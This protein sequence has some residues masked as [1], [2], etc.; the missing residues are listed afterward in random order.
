MKIKKHTTMKSPNRLLWT[1]FFLLVCFSSIKS[2]SPNSYNLSSIYDFNVTT[3]YDIHQAA[4]NHVWIGT[5]QGL[6][7]FDGVFFKKYSSTNFQTEYSEI[8]ED[9]EGRIWCQNFTGQIF[10]IKNSELVLFKDIN[11]FSIDG[12]FN[13]NI[14]KFPK[15]YISTDQGCFV[16]DFYNFK[17]ETFF[18][19]KDDSFLRNAAPN[20]QF[21]FFDSKTIY[22]DGSDIIVQNNKTK[23]SLFDYSNIYNFSYHLFQEEEER[24]FIVSNTNNNV[25][26]IDFSEKDISKNTTLDIPLMNLSS[27]YYD[28]VHQ[29]YWIG[30]IEGLFVFN[31]AFKKIHHFFKQ[32]SISSI[33]KD[34]ENNFWVGTLNNGI[35]IIPSIDI[36]TYDTHF[37][38]NRII[39]IKA[40]NDSDLYILNDAKQL[41][42]Y[43]FLKKKLHLLKD[44]DKKVKKIVYNPIMNGFYL[45]GATRFYSIDKNELIFTKRN[46]IKAG[47]K[48]SDSTYLISNTVHAQIKY[49]KNDSLSILRNKRSYTNA[50]CRETKYP[51]VSYSDGLF[52]YPA[53]KSVEIRYQGK[54]LLV[55]YVLTSD[56]TSG[57]WACDLQGKL[58]K[59][60]GRKVFLVYDFKTK[61][62][63]II[64]KDPVLFLTTDQ[65]IIKYHIKNRKLDYINK[66]DGLASNKVTGLEIIQDSIY[67]ATLAGLSKVG[68]DY[69][70]VNKVRPEVS[71]KGI[72]INGAQFPLQKNYKLSFKENN[73]VVD[74][75]TYALRSQKQ[76]KFYYRIANL[77]KKWIENQG[78]SIQFIALNPGD[79]HL[80]IKAVNEDHFESKNTY[81]IH[82]N[83]AYPFYQK[84]WFY[85]L[86]ICSSMALLL[87]I[88]YNKFKN[89]NLEKQLANS[90]ITTIK[91]QMNPHFM[92]NAM[93]TIQSLI[94]KEDKEKAYKYLTKLAFIV[95]ENLN[96]SD[97]PF[98][99]ITDELKLLT[100]YLELEKL[101]FKKDFEYQIVVD[102]HLHDIQIPSMIIQPFLENA[103]KHGLLHKKGLQKVSISFKVEKHLICTIEDNGIGRKASQA[104]RRERAANR[105]ESFS[106]SSIEKRFD[107][108]KKYYK[109][110][111]GFWYED[112]YEASQAIGTRV[113]INIPYTN[114][115]E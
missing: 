82:F 21:A 3:I 61:I 19:S 32:E 38:N 91:A 60:K 96:M 48:L 115:Y 7:E 102:E 24:L 50:I 105:H 13:F 103:I 43:D 72:K 27:F 30:T 88:F 33:T 74:L 52:Y 14:T 42:K 71:I 12:L 5:D 78:N 65:G 89:K 46:N 41:Y 109:L 79:Y 20:K 69:T 93:N 6:F 31:A 113:T 44:L 17:I 80:E 108:L 49:Y 9:I 2:Q 97:K 67:V 25:T 101:R 58:F 55:N 111:L 94:L 106:T 36:H 81:K 29:Q 76:F 8:K 18:K 77:D 62:K 53:N 59:I 95:R 64:H 23:V 37:G 70:Y 10:Y 40:I 73:I 1:F 4:N 57:V 100:T 51:Y 112:L 75:S 15:I 87:Y 83:I 66:L 56:D 86:I 26:I 16:S 63:K 35:F 68:L 39:D 11:S 104:I 85:V 45:S 92:F 28:K 90:T 22:A 54:P 84:W 99:A 107:L 110:N 98:I 114:T 47:N 34:I